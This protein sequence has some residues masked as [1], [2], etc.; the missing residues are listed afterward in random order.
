M[1][2]RISFRCPGCNARLRAS[3]D[4]IGRSCPCPKCRAEVQVQPLP[5]TEEAPILVLDSGLVLPEARAK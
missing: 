1:K 5:P 2:S 3:I 4:F